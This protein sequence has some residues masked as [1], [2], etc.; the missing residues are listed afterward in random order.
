MNIKQWIISHKY[1]IMMAVL[2]MGLF[3]LVSCS[4]QSA[5][6]TAPTG[7]IGGGCG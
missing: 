2:V 1:Q 4:T 7:P 5:P 3:L 6:P